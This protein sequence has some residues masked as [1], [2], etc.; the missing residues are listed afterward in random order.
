MAATTAT[1]TPTA[2]ATATATTAAI[3]TDAAADRRRRTTPT[4]TLLHALPFVL[5]LP[6]L[7]PLWRRRLV[8]SIHSF[9][10]FFLSK[11]QAVH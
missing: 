10:S 4:T 5:Q 2:T 1:A 11:R 8:S 7:P 6:L 3:A 9:R